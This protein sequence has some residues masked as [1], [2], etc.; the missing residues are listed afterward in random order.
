MKA[1]I[2][3]L[4]PSLMRT[5]QIGPACDQLGALLRVVERL[6][7]LRLHHK[8]AVRSA[9]AG[10]AAAHN[11]HAIQAAMKL[12]INSAY[13]YMGAGAM[14]LFA[15]RQAADEVTRRGR[16]EAVLDHVVA[17]LRAR[18]MAL[19][20]GDTDGVYFAVPRG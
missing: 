16:S 9:P 3:S 18:G 13:G 12:I 14:A 20:E 11:H 6:T 19:I 10:S 7:D 17:E 15:D 1:D 2:A 4:Y 5:Y 8:D